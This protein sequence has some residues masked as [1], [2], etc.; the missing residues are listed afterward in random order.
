[1]AAITYAKDTLNIYS[2]LLLSTYLTGL[3]LFDLTHA[4]MK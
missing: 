1:M 4:W 2:D 3:S